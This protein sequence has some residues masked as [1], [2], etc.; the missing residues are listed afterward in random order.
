MKQYLIFITLVLSGLS[1]CKKSD[2]A[3]ISDFNENL[4]IKMSE[5][6][7]STSRTLFLDCFTEKIYGCLNHSIQS[8]FIQTNDKITINFIRVVIPSVCLT[9]LGPASTVIKLEGLANKIYEIEL[10]FGVTKILGQLNV[11]ENSY[12]MILPTQAKVE[13]VNP[14]LGRVPNNTIYGIVHYHAAS[15]ATTVQKFIDSLQFY[16]AKPVLYS[17]GD[18]GSFRIESNGQIKQVQDLGYY[19]TQY[20]IFNYAN[21]SRQIK[22]LVK[23]FGINYSNLLN[24]RLTTTKGETFYSWIP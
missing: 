13:F 15:T 17:Q 18:Y 21:D 19:F 4:K 5:T 24:I 9:S 11:S 14:N 6:V 2:T 7:D 10:N 23:R 3:L 8:T 22:D 16:G 1:S 20:Y 12:K